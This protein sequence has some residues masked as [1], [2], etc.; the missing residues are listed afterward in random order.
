[1]HRYSDEA[2]AQVAHE[3]VRGMQNILDDL[4]PSPPWACLEADARD[5]AVEGVRVARAGASPR[6]LH[7]AWVRRK[8]LE[9][10]IHGPSKDPVL[11][12]HPNIVP[13]DELLP[14]ERDKDVLFL[15]VV[16]ALTV[17]H[18]DVAVLTS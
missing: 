17:D 11:R 6:S 10:W 13:W 15:M 4:C 14:G 8:T 5:S 18:G 7:E 9:G 12:T 1:M 3:A 2:V 16:T